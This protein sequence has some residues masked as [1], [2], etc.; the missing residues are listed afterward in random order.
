MTRALLLLLLVSAIF[1]LGWV[2]GAA[3]TRRKIADAV[4]TGE[5]SLNQ[6]VAFFAEQIESGV[7]IGTGPP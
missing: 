6:H 2:W 5:L 1:L 7:Y 4:M 3:N